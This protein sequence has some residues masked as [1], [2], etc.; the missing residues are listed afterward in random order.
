MLATGD[1]D[2]LAQQRTGYTVSTETSRG[3]IS[4]RAG[5]EETEIQRPNGLKA[6]RF[7]LN[8][9]ERI[10]LLM[11]SKDDNL[12]MRFVK[13]V[14]QNSMSASIL[15]ANNPPTPFRRKRIEI[16]NPTEEPQDVILLLMGN[17]GNAYRME[18]ERK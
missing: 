13:P 8:P 12:V 4:A 9:K 3:T 10:K 11:K 7:Q 6:L 15:A 5:M 17:C 2:Q 16:A 1:P 14:K 18:I